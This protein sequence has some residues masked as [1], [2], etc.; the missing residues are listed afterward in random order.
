MTKEARLEPSE[1]S[2][3]SGLMPVAST[4]LESGTTR[5]SRAP[6]PPTATSSADYNTRI[7]WPVARYIEDKR[8]GE[9]LE[10]LA[11]HH[12]LQV[13]WL[14]GRTLWISIAAFEGFLREVRVLLGTEQE[15]MTA[16]AYRMKEAYGPLRYILWAMSPAAVLE[17]GV[18]AFRLMSKIG[19][20][21]TVSVGRTEYSM[22]MRSAIPISREACLAR[23]AARRRASD[24]LRFFPQA[25]VHEEACLAFGDATCEY[26]YTWYANNRLFPILFGGIIGLAVGIGIAYLEH[27]VLIAVSCAIVGNAWSD[28]FWRLAARCARTKARAVAS[29]KRSRSSLTKRARRAEKFWRSDSANAIG[30]PSSK[31]RT[32]RDSTGFRTS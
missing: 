6:S 7:L 27:S 15:F 3:S 16:C 22:R 2:T 11:S 1:E 8:G 12:G 31:R 26:G 29:W 18:R 28:T 24:D 17:Q 9:A 13:E 32:R 23:Q 10:K 20:I 4:S 19:D 14:D 30:R 21:E 25:Q 5:I